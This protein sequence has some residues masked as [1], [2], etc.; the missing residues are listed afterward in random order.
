MADQ[1]DKPKNTNVLNAQKIVWQLLSGNPRKFYAT[2]FANLDKALGGGLTNK[3]YVLGGMAATGKTT[4]ALQIAVEIARDG[5][6]VLFVSFE[7]SPEVL[8][9]KVISR[10]TWISSEKLSFSCTASEINYS[11]LPKS[12][13]IELQEY[14]QSDCNEIIQ[15]LNFY[16]SH[17]RITVD[18]IREAIIRIQ[19]QTNKDPL[20]VIDY[21]QLIASMYHLK[22]DKANVDE[23]VSQLKNI[24]MENHIPVLVIS[25]L[26]RNSY[27]RKISMRSFKESGLIEY[28][29]DVLMGL[30]QAADSSR[31]WLN[32]YSDTAIEKKTILR[33]IK[34][35]DEP[36]EIEIKL[37]F[38]A[39]FNTFTEM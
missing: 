10:E 11:K 36:G 18:N 26:N 5:N 30:E 22:D 17:G 12:E 20:L 16:E 4:L 33:I 9:S 29:A 34:N 14:I 31:N 38:N 3:L 32:D 19:V 1:S 7:Q 25:S 27:D 28:T 23:A 6:P 39:A 15:N 24:V 21:L 8:L 2:G 13:L 37:S 35:K